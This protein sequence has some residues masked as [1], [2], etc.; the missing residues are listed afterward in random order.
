M[1]NSIKPTRFPVVSACATVTLIT[2]VLAPLV[3]FGLLAAF[4]EPVAA[5]VV[6]GGLL[7]WATAMLSMAALAF[8]APMGGMAIAYAWFIGMM[9]RMSICL[10]G[11][12]VAKLHFEVPGKPLAASLAAFYLP[13]LLVELAW[14]QRHLWLDKVG[15]A[16]ASQTAGTV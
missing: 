6:A 13:L 7:C 11:A 9:V 16:K 1:D 10:G 15:R 12:W 14:V 2:A 8:T 5:A 3:Y 4:G